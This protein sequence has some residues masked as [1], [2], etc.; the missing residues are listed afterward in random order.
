MDNPND[1][2]VNDQMVNDFFADADGLI[3]QDT[4]APVS[5]DIFN[6]D[7]QPPSQQP[8]DNG[9]NPK[10]TPQSQQP[11]NPSSQQQAPAGQQQQAASQSQQAPAGPQGIEKEFFKTDDKGNPVFDIDAALSKLYPQNDRAFQ[12]SGVKDPR[13]AL[14]QAPLQQQPQQPKEPEK[15]PWQIEFEK[16]E[17]TRKTYID[18]LSLG[19]NFVN[20]ALKAG[21]E[22]EQAI[23]YA[24]QQIQWLI[25]QEMAKLDYQNRY[26]ADQEE[27]QRIAKEK[28]ILQLK[29]RSDSVH[30]ML[31]TKAGGKDKFDALIFGTPSADGKKLQGG[32]GVDVLNM[33]FDIA[34]LGQQLPS[35]GNKLY[36]MY[37]DWYT[38]FS[39][40][41]NNLRF[42]Y[43][44]A[45]ARLQKA[46]MPHIINFVRSAK[47]REFYMR[48][49]AQVKAPSGIQAP[50]NSDT[51]QPDPLN[52]YLGYDYQDP[53]DN[54]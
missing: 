34:H 23:N 52:S 48:G 31:Y 47:D 37:Q 54:V 4:G 2:Q 5:N 39:A 44:V 43:D 24:N 49:Q 51:T 17:Q 28:E 10:S 30:R 11:A 26:K 46:M 25:D 6:P 12:Y 3:D 1:T 42:V 35:D 20:E 40:N 9:Q 53:F 29:P 7:P 18:N 13:G 14:Q 19:L 27:K 36:Q 22:P 21:Y 33:L 50:E 38:R 45:M 15:E 16:R 41:E 8:V 32:Y